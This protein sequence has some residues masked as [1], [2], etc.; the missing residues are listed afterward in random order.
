[1]I[2]KSFKDHAAVLRAMMAKHSEEAVIR[3]QAHIG[4]SR[5]RT[6]ALAAEQLARIYH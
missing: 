6:R 4:Q 2:R 5:E 3:M 1:L